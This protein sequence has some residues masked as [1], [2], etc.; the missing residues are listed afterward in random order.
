MPAPAA[1]TPPTM[2]DRIMEPVPGS[3]YAYALGAEASSVTIE[4]K[5]NF[6]HSMFC[7]S[8]ESLFVCVKK[9]VKR[10]LSRRDDER[11]HFLETDSNCRHGVIQSFSDDVRG[12]VRDRL[13]MELA[14]CN[15][16]TSAENDCL[17]LRR[18][19]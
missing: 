17:F 10:V 1:A 4:I 8:P 18:T 9:L 14:P 6:D 5:A 11:V 2:A 16:R 19:P 7:M 12:V 15:D 3:I 13:P